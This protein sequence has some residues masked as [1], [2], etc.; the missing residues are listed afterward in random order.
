MTLDFDSGVGVHRSL[1]DCVAAGIYRRGLKVVAA[2]LDV[3]PG[4]L[5]SALSDDPHRKF[6]VDELE[7]YIEQ[8]R[9]YSPIFYLAK[10]FLSDQAS[11]RDAALAQV[12]EQLQS[13]LS[14]MAAAG[15]ATTPQ[16]SRGR[17]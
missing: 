13:V 3:S 7:K 6:S 2:D 5:S 4:N 16:S 14:M 1:R 17:K 8:Y 9:D 15:L 11:A 12:N 10:R